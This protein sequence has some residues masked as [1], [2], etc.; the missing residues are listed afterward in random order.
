MRTRNGGRF[1]RKALCGIL[2][3]LAALAVATSSEASMTG[4]G[5]ITQVLVANS[6]ITAVYFSGPWTGAPACATNA[7]F[8]FVA[9]TAATQSM[10]SAIMTAFAAGKRVQLGGNGTCNAVS[11]S[12]DLNWV[13]VLQ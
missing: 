5:T 7:R 11:D 2:A 9:N 4:G 10:L 8:A 12:E 3:G 6:G 13:L 1:V